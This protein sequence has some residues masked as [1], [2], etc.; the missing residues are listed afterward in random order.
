MQNPI[1]VRKIWLEHYLQ[2]AREAFLGRKR[3]RCQP[4]NIKACKYTEKL[5]GPYEF[6]VAANAELTRPNPSPISIADSHET[7]CSQGPSLND[8]RSAPNS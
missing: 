3:R 5:N 4:E 2:R 1:F 6:A 7:H 8:M